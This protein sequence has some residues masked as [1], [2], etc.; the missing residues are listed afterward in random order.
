MTSVNKTCKECKKKINNQ[1]KGVALLTFQGE[2]KIESMY[3]HF[4]CYLDWLNRCILAKADKRIKEASG[5]A[6]KK[7]MKKMP[8]LRNIF[9]GM[10]KN[11]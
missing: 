9:E 3:F 10:F 8:E 11:G 1:D 4:N 2:K 5:K 7:T 6:F